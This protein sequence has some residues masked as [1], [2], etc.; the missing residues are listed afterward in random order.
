[1]SDQP[2]SSVATIDVPAAPNSGTDLAGLARRINAAHSKMQAAM[3][4]GLG[5]AI[6][7][8]RLLIEAKA[9][10]DH[11]D[12]LHWLDQNC[13]VSPRTASAY[14][15]VARHIPKL[16]AKSAA[17]ADLTL[18]NA[19]SKMASHAIQIVALP[20]PAAAET[21]EKAQTEPHERVLEIARKYKPAVPLVNASVPSDWKPLPRPEP[22]PE[23]VEARRL[24]GAVIV[25]VRRALA[26]AREHN[27]KLSDDIV[28][29]ALNDIYCEIQEAAERRSATP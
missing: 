28:L 20:E 7:A 24:V 23:Q 1:V 3:K 29:T 21:L 2:I 14:M 13:T 12:W 10:V 26:S 19:L 18:R 8:G 11:G 6:E 17:V 27:P 15:R 25:W 5:H 16:E 4:S 22:T 9:A